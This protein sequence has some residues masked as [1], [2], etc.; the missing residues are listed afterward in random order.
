M[1]GDNYCATFF[2]VKIKKEKHLGNK[3]A[4]SHKE[5]C[6]LVHLTMILKDI[7]FLPFPWM[8]IYHKLNE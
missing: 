2:E 5:R 8:D 7:T 1:V 4:F 3:F 6:P